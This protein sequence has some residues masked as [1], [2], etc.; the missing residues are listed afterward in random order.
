VTSPADPVSMVRET[1]EPFPVFPV[2]KGHTI[3]WYQT[4]NEAWW[5]EIQRRA[6]HL[7][8]IT[9]DTF[10]R[11]FGEAPQE[12]PR[13]QCYLLDASGAPIGTAT[14]WFDNNYH[15][16]VWGRPHW[17]AILPTWQGRGLGKALLSAV[18]RRLHELHPERS[19]LR[20]AS[21]RLAAIHLYMKFGFQPEIRLL[22]DRPVWA[23]ILA[24]L[25]N[26]AG[27]S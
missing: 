23:H 21:Q 10:D 14:A 7:T 16:R 17:V 15:G 13:R 2:P 1:C 19:F 20:T 12:L 5:Y 3:A 9:P 27:P 26:S 6:D 18:C 4:G 22:E 24:Q 25:K 8:A 11:Y